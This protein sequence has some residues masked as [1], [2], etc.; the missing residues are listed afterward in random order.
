MT[1]TEASECVAEK[2][3][4]VMKATPSPMGPWSDLMPASVLSGLIVVVG[5]FAVRRSS[6]APFV[7]IALA[8]VPLLVAGALVLSMRNSREKVV[9]WLCTV[10]FP[11]DNFNT[12]L[13]G[14]GDTIEIVFAQ[15]AELPTRATLQPK[16]DAVSEDVLLVKERPEE[17]SIEIRLGVIDSKRLPLHTNH[18]R[19]KRF[20]T[21][22]ETVIV[23][24]SKTAPIERM[25]VV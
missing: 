7:V 24:L 2:F 18:A 25:I 19:W 6:G 14:L 17:R 8:A 3:T 22:M 5:F 4:R 16:L 13:V 23:P 9:A 21:V 15:G 20:V 11:I 1:P 12:L 10:P